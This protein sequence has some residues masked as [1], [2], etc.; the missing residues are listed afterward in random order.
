MAVGCCPGSGSGRDNLRWGGGG[1][2]D[3][4]RQLKE[5]RDG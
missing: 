3:D 1:N 2:L 5:I 4:E